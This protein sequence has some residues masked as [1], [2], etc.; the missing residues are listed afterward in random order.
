MPLAV[1]AASPR[2]ATF[3]SNRRLQSKA[4]R[5]QATSEVCVELLGLSFSQELDET[6]WLLSHGP[7]A[8]APALR[9]GPFKINQGPKRHAMPPRIC[10][11]FAKLLP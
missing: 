11:S 9:A 7:V 1:L 3:G 8:E 4:E 10:K 5:P 2:P 6:R